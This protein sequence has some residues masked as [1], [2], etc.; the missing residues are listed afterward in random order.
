MLR[1]CIRATSGGPM[2]AGS[3]GLPVHRA[4]VSAK[5]C[6]PCRRRGLGNTFEKDSGHDR[7]VWA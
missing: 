3:G 5:R 4:V 1:R 6:G 2:A 7:V